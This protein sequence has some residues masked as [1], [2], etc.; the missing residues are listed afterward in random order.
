MLFSLSGLAGSAAQ[1]VVINELMYHP[2]HSASGSEDIRQEWMELYNQDT[3]PV[4]LAG[5]RFSN[6]IE[7]VLPDVTLEAGGYL[8]VAADVNVFSVG[9]PM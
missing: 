6:G 8:V 9:I 3:E 5:W 1:T 2:Y 7:Y 4:N